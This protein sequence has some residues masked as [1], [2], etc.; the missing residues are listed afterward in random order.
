RPEDEQLANTLEKRL[1]E[2]GRHQDLVD[3]WE[4]RL[5]VLSESQALKTRYSIATRLLQALGE[6]ELAYARVEEF[7]EAGGSGDAACEILAQI[8]ALGSAPVEVRRQALV[9]L[10]RLHSEAERPS[11]VIAVLAQ[12][13]VLAQSDE[14]RIALRRR[15][16]ELLS[17]IG[18]P[19]GALTHCAEILK[20]DPELDEVRDQ[21]RELAAAADGFAIYSAALV[22]AAGV[23]QAGQ[24]RVALLVEAAQVCRE[25]LDDSAGAIDLFVRCESD[26]EADEA[27]RLL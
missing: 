8:A 15:S 13:L 25:Q 11:E 24:K 16:S 9:L 6:P 27:Y 4:A 5:S 1:D 14:E 18:E 7:L 20:L 2:Q 3:I 23:A 21:A 17:K 22:V 10:E 26:P 12:A 19:M